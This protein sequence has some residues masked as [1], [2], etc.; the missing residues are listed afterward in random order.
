AA[1]DMA[2]RARNAAVMGLRV[3][4]LAVD[5]PVLR[6][7]QRGIVDRL[8]RGVAT[9]L[10]KHGVTMV[11]GE[12]ALAARNRVAVAT[13]DGSVRY[14]A[15]RGIVIATGARAQPIAVLRPDGSRVLSAT[16]A[17]FLDHL[18]ATV[19]VVGADYLAVE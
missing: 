12:G 18:P 7:W 8:A 2:H 14:T 1:A 11:R 6:A 13:P 17:L 19:A 16:D 15:R 4:E 10:D 9:L 3:P 5:M